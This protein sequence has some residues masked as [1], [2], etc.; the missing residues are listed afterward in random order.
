MASENISRYET[1]VDKAL[2]RT[3]VSCR[4]GGSDRQK[5]VH[6]LLEI[7][8][9]L[10]ERTHGNFDKIRFTNQVIMINGEEDL[11]V[12]TMVG[13]VRRELI[14][15]LGNGQAAKTLVNGSLRHVI[16]GEHALLSRDKQSFPMS[17]GLQGR[18]LHT[19]PGGANT[20]LLGDWR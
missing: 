14:D 12:N 1:L 6:E 4:L 19:R 9:L 15:I 20:T 8:E 2:K 17:E 13:S 7:L 18:E 11:S 3:R 5:L 10:R 16:R